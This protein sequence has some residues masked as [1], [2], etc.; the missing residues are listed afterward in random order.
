S[1]L[2]LE[3]ANELEQKPKN[4]NEPG[5]QT[6]PAKPDEPVPHQ[7]SESYPRK[8]Q[9]V[10][11]ND[12]GNAAARAD[13][14]YLRARIKGD[15]RQVADEC[16]HCNERQIT[17][18]PQKIFHGMPKRQQKIHVAGQMNDA[19]MKEERCDKCESTEPRCLRWNQSE[20]V[21]KL[22]Q[23]QKRRKTDTNDGS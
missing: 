22:V 10:K 3:S 5:R 11:R 21:N 14:R 13:A 6:N 23:I 7:K 9:C 8:I 15:M 4:E 17:Q 2:L 1:G 18:W 16:C 20:T 19:C 12:A